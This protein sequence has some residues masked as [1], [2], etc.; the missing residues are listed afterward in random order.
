M[1]IVRTACRYE[2]LGCIEIAQ[3]DVAQFHF[4]QVVVV[5]PLVVGARKCIVCLV[6]FSSDPSAANSLPTLAC[7]FYWNYEAAPTD[8]EVFRDSSSPVA[9]PDPLPNSLPHQLDPAASALGVA[10]SFCR[11]GLGL[12]L[13][14][15]E[16][17][18]EP[19]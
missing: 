17:A 14:E 8:A 18:T 13:L 1:H 5:W 16:P 19:A 2:L 3:E 12:L 6:V 15:F 9:L 7:A 11:I 10:P 4:V